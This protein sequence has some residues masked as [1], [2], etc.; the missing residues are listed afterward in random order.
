MAAPFCMPPGGAPGAPSFYPDSELRSIFGFIE[1]P[2]YCFEQAAVV[3]PRNKK[4]H[5]HRTQRRPSGR[6]Y[7][8]STVQSSV[9]AEYVG[10]GSRM[11]FSLQ[12]L[13]MLMGMTSRMGV[14]SVKEFQRLQRQVSRHCDN[15]VQGS[16]LRQDD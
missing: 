9:I 7:Q 10:T 16:K 6:L 15:L 8:S 2:E 13:D 11:L 1:D 14:N 4:K 3:T 12:D 5:V